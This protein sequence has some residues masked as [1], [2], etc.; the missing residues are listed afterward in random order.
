MKHPNLMLG[1]CFVFF[2]LCALSMG[3]KAYLLISIVIGLAWVYALISVTLAEK[4]VKL[5]NSLSSYK[6][7][8]GDTVNMVIAVSHRSPLPIAPVALKMRKT[9]NTPGAT[10]HLTRLGS[11]KQRVT[12]TFTAEHVGAMCPGVESYVVS[13]VFGFFRREYRPD[14]KG[15]E[16]LVLP[17]PFEVE[18]LRFAAG[19]LGVE[20]MRKAME[21]PSSPAD[22]RNY[23]QGD[24]LKR[25]HWKMSARKHEI[26]VRQFE[27]PALPDAL[28]MLDTSPPLLKEGMDKEKA[29]FLQDTLLETA[30][31]V[32]NCQIRQDNSLR[33]PLVGDRPMEYNSR[34]GLPILLE[35]LARCTFNETEQF[36]RVVMMQMNEMRKIGAVVIITTRLSPSLTELIVR[37]RRLGPNVRIYL[38]SFVEDDPDVT[39]QVSRLQAAGAE[40]NYVTP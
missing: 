4:T 11:R 35:E 24:P 30:A 36:E 23:Q 9:A 29:S 21:D 38:C 5:E 2:M 33:L 3:N 7:T 8:R 20:T 37:M 14:L 34:M 16:L 1:I 40:V 28:L 12:Y 17:R 27:E 22:I 31:S 13:D 15:Q 39:P 10:L 19:D 6:V 18:P 25:I 26:M 32:V